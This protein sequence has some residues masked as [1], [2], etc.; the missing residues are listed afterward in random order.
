MG[1]AA[2]SKASLL[3]MALMPTPTAGETI[4]DEAVPRDM[5]KRLN[6]LAK[7]FVERRV[8]Q[9]LQGKSRDVYKP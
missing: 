7:L 8:E 3:K 6:A 9:L 2:G 1:K 5:R 4:M